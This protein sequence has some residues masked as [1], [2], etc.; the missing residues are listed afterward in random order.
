VEERLRYKMNRENT[1]G[2]WPTVV[3][4]EAADL[5][6]RLA[7]AA[8]AERLLHRRLRRAVRLLRHD[9]L[10]ALDRELG[11]VREAHRGSGAARETREGGK[12]REARAT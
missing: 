11:A 2:D 3:P 10:A 8:P 12:P 9:V 7:V 5:V 4:V 6:R 1:A